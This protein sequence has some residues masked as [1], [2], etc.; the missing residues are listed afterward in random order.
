MNHA[1]AFGH[2]FGKIRDWGFVLMLAL[3]ITIVP[4]VGGCSVSQAETVV[5]KVIADMPTILNI[6]ESVLAIVG[7]VKGLPAAQASQL[8]SEATAVEGETVADL[9][10]IQSVLTAYQSGLASAPAGVI[11]QLDT[12]VGAI[13]SNLAA[14]E[15]A[16]HVADSTTQ[17]AIAATVA[18]LSAFLLGVQSLIPA[19]V[20][21]SMPHV[22]KALAEN[23][24]K[25]GSGTYIVPSP[26]QLA[27]GFNASIEKLAP[28]AKVRV[29]W[30]RLAHV[31]IWP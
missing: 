20:A 16:F 7:A 8:S 14:L 17:A 25:A 9:K 26:R 18:A 4:A 15:T 5:Q 21:A 6:A 23:G 10:T 22:F 19:P 31:P 30:V 2:A 1:H 28:G 29:P 27:N 24:I 13:N 12:A 3:V 11:A